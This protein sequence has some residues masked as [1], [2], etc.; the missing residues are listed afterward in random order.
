MNYVP[1]NCTPIFYINTNREKSNAQKLPGQVLRRVIRYIIYKTFNRHRSMYFIYKSFDERSLYARPLRRVYTTYYV[2]WPMETPSV[3]NASNV[4]INQEF[5]DKIIIFY[6][7]R[8]NMFGVQQQPR[9]CKQLYPQ[10]VHPPAEGWEG[11]NEEQFSLDA[12]STCVVPM[13]LAGFLF[14]SLGGFLG[15]LKACVCVCVMMVPEDNT[16]NY[17]GRGGRHS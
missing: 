4:Y 5:Y 8:V 6:F 2:Q 17:N 10:R 11:R 7:I 14:G 1:T 13:R 15:T 16:Y 3:L 12:N 9:E